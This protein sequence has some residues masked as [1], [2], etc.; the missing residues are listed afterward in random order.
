V[1]EAARQ[2]VERYGRERLGE[3]AKLS[4]KTTEKVLAA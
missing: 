2:V 1:I 3:V 4:F